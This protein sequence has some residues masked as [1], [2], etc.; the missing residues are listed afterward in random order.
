MGISQDGGFAAGERGGSQRKGLGASSQ[1]NM[2]D[3]FRTNRSKR[4][5]VAAEERSKGIIKGGPGDDLCYICNQP[6]HIA[7][8]CKY[9]I[10]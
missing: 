5:H 9:G 2:F 10:N 8:D 3:Q 1:G 6:G 4:Y 7:K